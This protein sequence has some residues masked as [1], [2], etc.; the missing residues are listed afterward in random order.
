MKFNQKCLSQLL[1]GLRL[2]SLLNLQV[3]KCRALRLRMWMPKRK[4]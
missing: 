1:L 2:L 4:L 3:C